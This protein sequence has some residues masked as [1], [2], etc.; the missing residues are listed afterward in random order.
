MKK[1]VW[2]SLLEQEICQAYRCHHSL[3]LVHWSIKLSC[4]LSVTF[5][6]IS[7]LVSHSNFLLGFEVLAE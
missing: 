1:D 3:A 5:Q 7:L 4:I 2:H 6:S